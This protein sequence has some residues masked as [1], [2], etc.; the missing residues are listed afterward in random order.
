MLFE[1]V[2]FMKEIKNTM[3]NFLQVNLTNFN[4]SL[5]QLSV[6]FEEHKN[7][8]TA[9][10]VQLQT[11]IHSNQS[12]LDTKLELLAQNQLDLTSKLASL[13]TKLKD[14]N[15]SNHQQHLEE[16]DSSLNI[17][18]FSL[19]TKLEML[20]TNFYEHQSEIED[21]LQTNTQ[22]LQNNLTQQLED[23]NDHFD[24]LPVYTCGGTGGWRR[25][26]YL[27]MTDPTSTCPPGWQLTGYSKRTCG[28]ATSTARSC[29]S[30]TFPFSGV[31]YSRI[32]G[33]IAAYQF[34]QALAFNG[35][36]FSTLDGAYVDGVS[37]THGS[38]RLHIWTFA[39]GLSENEKL[40]GYSSYLCPCDA[41]SDSDIP[42]F[43]GKDYFCES[44][45]NEAWTLYGQYKLF[46]NDTLWDG[47]NCLDP[48]TSSCCSLHGPPY[49][50]KQ[51][52]ASTKDDIEA[53]ICLVDSQ[54]YANIA[55]Q[56]VEL[57]VK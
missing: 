9:E 19:D 11:S 57:Y 33:R 27:D 25:V 49:F 53:R 20:A 47:K 40:T 24:Q 12:S 23:I 28:R 41:N 44:G 42:P 13:D 37:L 21:Q 5:H 3:N 7:Q 36:S 18:Y 45:V 43:V 34:G 10:L 35:Y 56:L 2:P 22:Y 6:R 51:L 54:T 31:E 15:V 46:S 16:L 32:C 8:T 26:V 30:A 39:A 17:T 29:D 52:P 50:I 14:V 1:L 38:P 48:S 4:E 55:V